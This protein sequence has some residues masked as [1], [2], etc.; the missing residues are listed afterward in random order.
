MAAKY[1]SIFILFPFLGKIALKLKYE[2]YI[3][4]FAILILF[5]LSIAPENW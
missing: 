1:Y 4:I 3:Y 5:A 2:D